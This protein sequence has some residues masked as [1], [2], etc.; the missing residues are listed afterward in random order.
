[1]SVRYGKKDGRTRLRVS[2]RTAVL[3]AGRAGDD[4]GG[5]VGEEEEEVGGRSVVSVDPVQSSPVQSSPSGVE[6]R[7]VAR[8]GLA[9][10]AAAG[11]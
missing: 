4:G 6:L 2:S 8:A 10:A 7:A 3:I 11:C 9:A 1:M 5:G